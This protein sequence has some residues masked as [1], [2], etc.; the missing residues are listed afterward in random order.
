M[1]RG[2]Q[3]GKLAM[4]VCIKGEWKVKEKQ[5][6]FL[7][8][9][10]L[11]VGGTSRVWQA[12]VM[13]GSSNRQ[14]AFFCAIKYWIK[15]YNKENH[16]TLSSMDAEKESQVAAKKEVT[17]YRQIYSNQDGV[18]LSEYVGKVKLNYC[19]CVILPF[20]K[21]IQKPQ[22]QEALQKIEQLLRKQFYR[23][24]ETTKKHVSYQ[25]G[26]SDRRW[27]HVGLWGEKVVLF[28]LA[29]LDAK[30][31]NSENDHLL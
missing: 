6:E 8:V 27:R 22:R 23:Y 31:V 30:D 15:V 26:E 17:F 2:Y 18:D 12:V 4:E 7:I 28:D 9:Q 11:G 21:P 20:F 3:W 24:D 5:E 14:A 13:D 16:E 29:D 25:F 10:L 1:K 19:W